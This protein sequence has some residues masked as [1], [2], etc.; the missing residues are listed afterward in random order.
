MSFECNH[1]HT[2]AKNLALAIVI[3][4]LLTVVQ[5]VAGLMSGS[6]SLV[7]DAIHNLSDASSLFIAYI[8]ERISHWPATPRMPYGYGRAQIIGAFINSLTLIAVAIYIIYEVILRFLN[9]EPIDGWMVV[10]VGFV[11]LVIDLF[12]V[13]LTHPGSENN[14]NL[15]A[16]FIHNLTDALA[17]VV[18]II[19][20][21][22]I[23][24]FDFYAFDLIASVAISLFILYQSV[25]LIKNCLNH[26]MQAFPSDLNH[27][28]I[29]KEFLTFEDILEVK[30][31]YVWSMNERQKSLQVILKLKNSGH[32]PLLISSLK[33]RLHSKFKIEN[34][35]IE[36]NYE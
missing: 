22:L 9:P 20:G 4:V 32:S 19:S 18:V 21:T 8:A 15:R 30:Q 5:V 12:T 7:A 17:S 2:S 34:S 28:D 23:I 25:D 35:T 13:K 3:N 1:N 27:E 31:L 14:I 24:L 29:K 33:D 16:A 11:A 26:L 6:L 36:L 10:I